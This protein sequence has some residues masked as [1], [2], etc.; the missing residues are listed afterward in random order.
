LSHSNLIFLVRVDSPDLTKHAFKVISAAPAPPARQPAPAHSKVTKVKTKTRRGGKKEGDTTS[1]EKTDC[2][3]GEKADRSNGKKESNG[4]KKKE[5]NGAKKKDERRADAD[6]NPAIRTSAQRNKQVM[7]A[8]RKH[9]TEDW[10]LIASEVPGWT[11]VACKRRWDLYLDP[12]ISRRDPF[13]EE[14]IREILSFQANEGNEWTLLVPRLNRRCPGHV[15]DRWNRKFRKIVVDFLQ[16]LGFTLDEIEGD[17]KKRINY[18][19][20]FEEAVE[21]VMS[22]IKS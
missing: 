17:E 14:E 3:N 2:S 15:S 6:E 19:G 5:R 18:H 9:G 16:D 10:E 7:A 22:T 1:E 12:T 4:T 20:Y 11:A 21:A 13:T 8:I